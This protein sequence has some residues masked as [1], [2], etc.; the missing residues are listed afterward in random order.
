MN[1]LNPMIRRTSRSFHR[2]APRRGSALVEVAFVGPVALLLII[3]IIIVGIGVYR[4]QQVSTLAREG[5]RWASMRGPKYEKQTH[6]PQISANDVY[7][8]A[9]SPMLGSA[10]SKSDFNVELEW[11]PNRGSVIVTVSYPWQP[12][13]FLK[14]VELRSRAEAPVAR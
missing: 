14:P 13:A 1:R 2:V 7:D 8:K 6:S 3:G 11:G 9:I 12:Q 5:V 10:G 4:F